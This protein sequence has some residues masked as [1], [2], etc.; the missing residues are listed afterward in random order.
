MPPFD[1]LVYLTQ[2]RDQVLFHFYLVLIII[3]RLVLLSVSKPGYGG[4]QIVDQSNGLAPRILQHNRIS[5][6]LHDT[7]IGTI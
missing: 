5:M 6:G 3:G 2:F 1:N 4:Q 7:N